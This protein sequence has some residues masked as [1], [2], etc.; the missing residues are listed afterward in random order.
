MELLAKDIETPPFEINISIRELI[1][2][3]FRESEAA[4]LHTAKISFP[5][6]HQQRWPS[7][8]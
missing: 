3:G 8:R 6:V 7:S 1:C 5:R 2:M 4:K